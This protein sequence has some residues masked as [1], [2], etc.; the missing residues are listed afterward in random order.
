MVP[1]EIEFYAEIHKH[2]TPQN[3]NSPLAEAAPL[4]DETPA[5][6]TKAQFDSIR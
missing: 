2:E 5:E 6:Q 3:V 4:H 1:E